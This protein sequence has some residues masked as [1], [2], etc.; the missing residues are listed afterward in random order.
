MALPQ[1][2]IQ[3]PLKD[4]G[5]APPSLAELEQLL[6]SSM[7]TVQAFK[8]ANPHIS[9]LQKLSNR[10]K[11]DLLFVTRQQQEVQEQQG[12]SEQQADL[13][14]FG[15]L[16]ESR[17]QGIINNLRGFHGELMALHEAPG[18]VAVCK[19]FSSEP[20]KV[21]APSCN[22]TQKPRAGGSSSSPVAADGEADAAGDS[23]YSS[24][25]SAYG[26]SPAS[27][28][29]SGVFA[30]KGT[31]TSSHGT[32]GQQQQQLPASKR[33]YRRSNDELQQGP[34]S[35]Q[36]GSNVNAAAAAAAGSESLLVEVDVVAHEGLTWIE[37]KNQ[38]LFGLDSVHWQGSSHTKG[39]A[40][41]VAALQAVAAAPVN[42]RRW[43]CPAVVVFFPSGVSAEVAA[44]LR[45]MGV[46][47]ADGPGSVAA[48]PVPQPPSITNLDVTSLCALVSEVS[49]GDPHSPQLQ[50]WAART[51]HW[52]D[53]LAAQIQQPLLPQLHACL[54]NSQQLVTSC[55]AVQ[56]FQA[57]MDMF[58][59]PQSVWQG[60][61]AGDQAPNFC[62]GST[63]RRTSNMAAVLARKQ[64]GLTRSTTH[65]SSGTRDVKA[66]FCPMCLTAAIVANAPAIAAAAGGLAAAKVAMD[67]KGPKA[68]QCVKEQAAS[69][70]SHP[71]VAKKELPPITLSYEEW[72]CC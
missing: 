71:V 41:Q 17:L 7:E 55:L 51:V 34:A 68:Q 3:G 66:H 39:L 10:I 64:A 69:K 57:L 65:S 24:D 26:S 5:R 12:S 46:A 59:V 62:R 14:Q 25:S 6:A 33:T 61:S 18:V 49:W 21:W 35:P 58:S 16:T 44:A 63:N 22:V 38:E 42:S 45:A 29:S 28:G 56:Q 53:C 54:D 1:L 67:G 72:S 23:G 13:E 52:R 27:A 48:L 11:R 70:S 20:P 19:K 30:L 31:G 4:M 60:V 2:H 37:V 36:N 50:A 9:N 32:G 40:Q 8:A 43:R 47:V 15:G